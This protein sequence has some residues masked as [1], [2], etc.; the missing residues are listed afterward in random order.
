MNVI[1]ILTLIMLFCA[2]VFLL[3]WVFRPG[4]KEKYSKFS[5]IPLKREMKDVSNPKS[6]KGDKSERSKE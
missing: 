1:K 6:E 5:E 4:T 2:S 3:Y